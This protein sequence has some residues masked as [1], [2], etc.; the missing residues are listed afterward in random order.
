MNFDR[1]HKLGKIVPKPGYTEEDINSNAIS[2]LWE[3][4]EDM[5]EAIRLHEK[6]GYHIYTIYDRG[7]GLGYIESSAHFVNRYAY[8]LT[9]N[10]VKLRMNA[11][12]T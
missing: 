3:T 10:P 1:F 8:I 2:F 5:T 9:R 4:Y 12:L 6:E 7:R 11:C